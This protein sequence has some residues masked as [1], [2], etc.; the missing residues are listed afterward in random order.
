MGDAVLLEDVDPLRI[1]FEEAFEMVAVLAVGL[2]D[3]DHVFSGVIS[4]HEEDLAGVKAA[5]AE[6]PKAES[7]G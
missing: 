5:Q 1:I 6:S 7:K 2:D 3:I 4:A